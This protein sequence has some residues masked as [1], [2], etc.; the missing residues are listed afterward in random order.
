MKHW[1]RCCT[2]VLVQTFS[3]QLW[4]SKATDQEIVCARNSPS[5][6]NREKDPG[7]TPN[8]LCQELLGQ[9]HFPLFGRTL[10][11]S[12]W[13]REPSA[14]PTWL[15]QVQQVLPL[16]INHTS[17][18]VTATATATA[19]TTTAVLPWCPMVKEFTPERCWWTRQWMNFQKAWIPLKKR[20][21]WHPCG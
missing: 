18:T 8:L 5:D 12:A 19:A 2:D 9:T 16:R 6:P 13:T 15:A 21:V 20:W 3:L 1:R 10:T 7:I 14:W 4:F 11:T 17:T